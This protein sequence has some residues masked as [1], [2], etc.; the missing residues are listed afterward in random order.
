MDHM[1]VEAARAA[2]NAVLEAGERNPPTSR[3]Q[4]AQANIRRAAIE[5]L[6]EKGY[7]RISIN[8]V[9]RRADMAAGL[10]Y[11][12]YADLRT[13]CVSLIMEFLDALD[14]TDQVEEGVPRGDWFGRIKA[15]YRSEVTCYSQSPGLVQCI[16]VIAEE[17]PELGWL[18]RESRHL[19]SA[20]LV[21][22][23]ARLFPGSQITQR[24]SRLLVHMLGSLGVSTL[25]EYYIQRRSPLLALALSDDA[26]VEWMAALFYRGLFLQNPPSGQLQHAQVLAL[27]NKAGS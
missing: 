1:T 13:L 20:Q 21:S 9:A 23:I 25:D 2:I 15:H 7:R 18:W 4:R 5:L 24:D 11:H 8:D 3:G 12:Y 22:R 27:I 10:F 26:M 17:L 6:N 14:A 19:R 16:A